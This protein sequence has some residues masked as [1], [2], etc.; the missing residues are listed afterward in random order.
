MRVRYVYDYKNKSYYIDL[1][2]NQQ[3]EL[4]EKL[5]IDFGVEG[6]LERAQSLSGGAREDLVRQMNYFF[7]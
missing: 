6:A 2:K 3:D 7:R 4:E 1:N 5:D